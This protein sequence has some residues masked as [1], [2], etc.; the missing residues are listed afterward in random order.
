MLGSSLKDISQAAAQTA[1]RVAVELE[2]GNIKRAA[3]RLGVTDRAIQMRRAAGQLGCKAI[4][5]AIDQIRGGPRSGERTMKPTAPNGATSGENDGHEDALTNAAIA[6]SM[7]RLAFA[8]KA[9]R[10]C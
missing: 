8:T 5:D 7:P 10:S 6:R 3:T 1:M 4:G 9:T 2:R